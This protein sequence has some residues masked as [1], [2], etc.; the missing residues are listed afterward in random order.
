MGAQRPCLAMGLLTVYVGFLGCGSPSLYLPHGFGG[1]GA[2]CSA[3]PECRPGLLCLEGSCQ[4]GGDLGQGS[5]CDLSESCGAGLYC[6]PTRLC[7]PA[8]NV[9]IGGACLSS[10]ECVKGSVCHFEGISS[11]LTPLSYCRAAGSADIGAECA[12]D[13]DCLS[14]L[15]C[16][17]A[18]D[19][20]A[21]CQSSAGN[22]IAD[23][24][25]W[26]GESCSPDESTPR[27]Y[28]DIPRSGVAKDFYRL[29]FPNDLRRDAQGFVDIG[30]HPSPGALLPLDV[31]GRYQA[32]LRSEVTGFSRVPVVYFRFSQA[33]DFA[34][35]NGDGVQ[36]IRLVDI[37]KGSPEYGRQRS[38]ELM[39]Y[40][41]RSSSKYI[42]DHWLALQPAQRQPLRPATTYAVLLER[43]VRDL[44]GQSFQSSADL[45]ALLG[46]SPPSDPELQTAYLRYAPLRAY[47]SS[48]VSGGIASSQVLNAALFTT[49]DPEEVMPALRQSVQNLSSTYFG[50]R[51]LTLCQSGTRSPCA[52]GGVER[53]C[54]I[55]DPK[56]SVMELHG[57]LNL[58][59]FQRGTAPYL[60]EGGGIEINGNSAKVQRGETVCFALVV[61]RFSAVPPGGFP[62]VIFSQGVGET[63]TS[64]VKRGLATE[65][66]LGVSGETHSTAAVVLSL[67]LPQHGARRGDSSAAA[68]NLVFNY[69]N[70]QAAL[71]TLLQ[72]SADLFSLRRALGNIASAADLLINPR[73]LRFN[74]NRVVLFG[75]SQGAQQGA[76]ALPYLRASANES[77]LAA[78][79]SGLGVD[80]SRS[81][82]SREAPVDIAAGLPTLLLDRDASGNLAAGNFHPLLGLFQNYFDRGDGLNYAWRYRQSLPAGGV[83]HHLF[84]TY[85]L[86]DRYAPE[87][88]MQSFARAA[89]LTQVQPLLA[90]FGLTNAPAPL[91]ANVKL[92]GQSYTLGLR[93]YE[94]LPGSEGHFVALEA[95]GPARLQGLRFLRQALAGQTPAIRD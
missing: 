10:A 44:Q 95:G 34:T 81:L 42:C 80:S 47:L 93:Q 11:T 90:P 78:L 83:A 59:I 14:G 22:F 32:A 89:A 65:L 51:D 17:R 62:V 82:M 73:V 38:Y 49:A 57:R 4:P 7:E 23:L 53:S 40:P 75:H 60:E 55:V 29:P 94:A 46:P 76:I 84:M 13:L 50:V 56:A 24:P 52:D 63:F 18:A 37:S 16:S 41:G 20:W 43:G 87:V 91:S 86:G 79:W 66:A 5:P 33:Y 2:L 39:G 6:A 28:F 35:I 67:E 92:N 30:G 48:G 8:G 19:A 69:A 3:S 61:P 21:S 27:A 31:V 12:R 71:G 15:S 54:T 88:S 74:G 25:S 77:V 26:P 72:G 58:P 64:V 70:P 36:R 85:G 68:E 45:D 1:V 9:A